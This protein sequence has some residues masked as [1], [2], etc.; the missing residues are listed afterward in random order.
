MNPR[1]AIVKV[2]GSVEDAVNEAVDFL[3]GIERYAKPGGTYL[4][5][6]NLFTTKTADEGATTHPD[7]YMTLAKMIKEA[8]AK[9]VVGECPA[10]AAYA[11]P[12]VVFDG[13]GVRNLCRE[14]RV[15]LNVLDR[16]T[17]EKVVNPNAEVLKEF[18]VPRFA[19]ECDGIINAPKLKTHDLTQVTCAVK[20]LFGLQQGGSKGNH[21]VRTS[22]DSESFSRL[23]VDLYQCIAGRVTLSVVD[24][25][26]AM[27]GD[28]PTTGDPL[29]LG[30]IIAGDDAVAVDMVATKI[31]GW[32]PMGVGTNFISAE[33]G[34]GPSSLDDIEILGEAIDDVVRPFKK[35]VTF[36]DNQMFID[37]RMLIE[38]DEEKCAGCGICAKVCPA[39]AITMK[40]I[41]E[42]ADDKCI[43]CFCCMELCPS[44]ALRAVR[45]E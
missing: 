10:S 22:N 18:W 5:K 2:E 14:A 8:G 4:V 29:D 41:P 15:E 32:D 25:V 6:P 39:E 24:A 30:L 19:L 28:G 42:F 40:G 23:L 38:C 45:G 37:F 1:V 36:S 7:V 26:V 13:L 43:Q 33:R 21:H 17:P 20:N 12:D 16:E 44:G 27:E 35:P 11:R 3:G 34:L 9:P 31:I